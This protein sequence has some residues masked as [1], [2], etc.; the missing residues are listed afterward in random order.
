MNSW[1]VWSLRL[2]IVT[3]QLP[4]ISDCVGAPSLLVM[5]HH[6][7]KKKKNPLVMRFHQPVTRN[8]LK[9]VREVWKCQ[10]AA[11]YMIWLGSSHQMVHCH[12]NQMLPTIDYVCIKSSIHTQTRHAKLYGIWRSWSEAKLWVRNWKRGMGGEEGRKLIKL[13][14]IFKTHL[15]IIGGSHRHTAGILTKE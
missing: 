14:V 7:K 9:G 3:S 2:F 12:R 1:G 10:M 5:G 11:G 13:D 4:D 8:M 15:L 6:G